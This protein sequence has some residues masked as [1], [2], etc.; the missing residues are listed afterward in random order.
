MATQRL[1][2]FF[3]PMGDSAG[4]GSTDGDAARRDA[5]STVGETEKDGIGPEDGEQTAH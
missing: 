4:G 5:S 2:Q 1:D 3:Q